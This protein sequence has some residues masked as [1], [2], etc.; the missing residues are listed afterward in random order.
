MFK[1]KYVPEID[2][3]TQELYE[4]CKN[5]VEELLGVSLKDV[6]LRAFNQK[7]LSDYKF[8]I[9]RRL[10]RGAGNS[11]P[12]LLAAKWQPAQFEFEMNRMSE[13]ADAY[14]LHRPEEHLSECIVLLQYEPNKDY[15]ERKLV[16][17]IAHAAEKRLENLDGMEGKVYDTLSEGFADYVALRMFADRYSSDR[18]IIF[19][20]LFPAFVCKCN[21]IRKRYIC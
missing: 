19:K 16:H 7:F 10:L 11:I 18:T 15:L 12:G 13:F 4:Y 3:S 17:E 2:K 8:A 20:S 5:G 14:H 6:P 9:H 1:P 21:S